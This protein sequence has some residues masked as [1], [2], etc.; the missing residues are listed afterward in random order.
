MSE[1]N[2]IIIRINT[3]DLFSRYPRTYLVLI[4]YIVNKAEAQY[5]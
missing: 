3:G 1:G 2:P 4:Y 5:L